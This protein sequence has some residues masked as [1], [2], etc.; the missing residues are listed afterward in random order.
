MIFYEITGFL[1][2][3]FFTDFLNVSAFGSS[4]FFSKYLINFLLN[5]VDNLSKLFGYVHQLLCKR[6]LYLMVLKI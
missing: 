4:V 5:T 1:R 3:D 6:T 2:G